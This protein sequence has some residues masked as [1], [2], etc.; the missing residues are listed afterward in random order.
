MLLRNRI[1]GEADEEAGFTLIEMIVVVGLLALCLAVALPW[2]K[3]AAEAGSI[4]RASVEISAYLRSARTRAIAENEEV[5]VRFDVGKRRILL[6][7]MPAVELSS[8]TQIELI[9]ARRELV[10]REAAVRFYP[11]GSSTGG[12]IRLSDGRRAILIEV[13]WLTGRIARREGDAEERN[14]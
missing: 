11:D 2:S 9:A 10:G 7:G 5:I 6:A 4:D 3:R 13:N 8:A 14:R 12:T 1:L